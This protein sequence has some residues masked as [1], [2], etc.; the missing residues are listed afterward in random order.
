MCRETNSNSTI[1]RKSLPIQLRLIN[2]QSP[3]LRPTRGEV[4]TDST[5]VVEGNGFSIG[6]GGRLTRVI[7]R[8]GPSL[9]S[10]ARFLGSLPT[11]QAAKLI[12]GWGQW[13]V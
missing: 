3:R 7:L 1:D 10:T 9:G 4:N 12:R 11:E 13:V 2:L 5:V 6:G 8:F